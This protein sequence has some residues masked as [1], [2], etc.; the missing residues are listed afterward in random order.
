M[1]EIKRISAQNIVSFADLNLDISSNV[2]TVVI[3]DNK[4]DNSQKVN[5]SG[6]S[7]LIEAIAIAL[8]GEPLRKV[9]TDEFISDWSDEASVEMTLHNS[10]TNKDFTISRFFARKAPQTIE[11]HIYDMEKGEEIDTGKT[12]QPSVNDYNKFILSEIGIAKADL[13]NYYILSGDSYKSFFEASDRAKKDI[14]NNLSNGVMIDQSIAVL[15]NDLVPLEAA[16]VAAN[17]N[18][19]K[20]NGSIESLANEIDQVAQKQVEMRKSK[21]EN[22]NKYR[23]CISAKRKEVREYE[24]NISK[25]NERIDDLKN[26]LS[27]INEHKDDE[28]ASLIYSFNEISN[29][30]TEHNLGGLPNIPELSH[31]YLSNLE[32]LKSKTRGVEKSIDMAK[33]SFELA[34]ADF[35]NAVSKSKKSQKEY[36]DLCLKLSKS[37]SECNEKLDAYDAQFDEMDRQIREQKDAKN[38][39]EK[40][41]SALGNILAG[42]ITCPK[43]GHEFSLSS[44]LSV[45]DVRKKIKNGE[46]RM[47]DIDSNVSEIKKSE[48]KMTAVYNALQDKLD[49]ID[50]Q[51]ANFKNIVQS[52]I[53]EK[54]ILNNHFNEAKSRLA[55]LD[56]ELKNLISEMAMNESKVKNL[57]T[58]LFESATRI[59]ST[60]LNTG[61]TYVDTQ[62]E[63]LATSYG[64]I[65]AYTN[66][67]AALEQASD[68]NLA[69]SLEKSKVEYEK[70]LEVAQSNLESAVKKRDRLLCLKNNFLEFK[71]H[72]ANTKLK[73]ISQIV[74]RVLE[75]IGSNIRVDLQGDKILKSGK[76]KKN[77][78]VQ[79][80]KNGIEC[81]SFFKFSKGER[82]RVNL[83]SIIALQY[84]TNT[85]CEEGK[86]LEL[87]VFDEILDSSDQLGF[88][89]Y[90]DMI[91]KLRITSLLITQNSLPENYPYSL[92][93]VKE[94][95]ISHILEQ[96][97]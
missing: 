43:C 14:I 19:F 32:S 7:A 65:E 30:F 93:V 66:S 34:K 25:A 23:D 1:W 38:A 85:N 21:E 44:D 24:G 13:Y 20:I 40:E 50:N 33:T 94:N 97:A 89:C 52:D 74:N 67:I 78:T 22:I 3:G 29:M 90:C 75:R 37:A 18:V 73:S 26:L 17:N 16:V 15:D 28:N 96:Q 60:S 6:K 27:E 83:A 82:C 31:T 92:T 87:L 51:K 54:I 36:D 61:K 47:A 64:S 62:R 56:V 49:D 48:S 10:F 69:E 84:L 42:Y 79:L 68:S 81:G 39:I 91:N 45:E 12:V 95:G 57:R 58:D 77:I 8:T 63:H 9:N 46:D 41:I 5:G 11:C 88:E 4:D 70:K 71:T 72:L 76:I 2:A 53:N 59:I 86:G 35:E 80:L 55:E